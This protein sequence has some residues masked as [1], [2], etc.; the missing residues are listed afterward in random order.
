MMNFFPYDKPVLKIK[1]NYLHQQRTPSDC[2]IWSRMILEFA[3]FPVLDF[4]AL[5][6]ILEEQRKKKKKRNVKN[7]LKSW[8]LSTLPKAKPEILGDS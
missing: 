5:P 8:S 3:E 2:R 4:V 1:E 7:E 6:M